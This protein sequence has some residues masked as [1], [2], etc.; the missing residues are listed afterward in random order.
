MAVVFF[1]HPISHERGVGEKNEA[2]AV[3]RNA[4]CNSAIP[5]PDDLKKMTAGQADTKGLVTLP[6]QR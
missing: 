5:W 6:R 1:P 3:F 4:T 2:Y